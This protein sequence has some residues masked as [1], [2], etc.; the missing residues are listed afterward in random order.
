VAIGRQVTMDVTGPGGQT[1]TIR[2]DNLVPTNGRFQLVDAKFSA[3]TDLTNPS[4]NLASRVTVNQRTVYGWVSNGQPVTVVVRG[5]N[6]ATANLTPGTT[7]ALEPS[8]Q[9]HV[10]GPTGIVVRNY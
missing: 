4:V 2:I 6:T 9:I 8:V 7:I 3:V 1:V 5:A 10:N